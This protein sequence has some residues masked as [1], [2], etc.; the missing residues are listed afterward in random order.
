MRP[1]K[2][3]MKYVEKCPTC[4]SSELI[5][6]PIKEVLS[7]GNNTALLTV[8]AAV[9][10]HCGE[11]LY[12]PETVRQFEKAQLEKMAAPYEAQETYGFQEI[13]RTFQVAV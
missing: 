7:G 12:T 2:R 11:R 1:D 6:K 3:L 4:G 8:N 13:G 9:C 10:L 5:E